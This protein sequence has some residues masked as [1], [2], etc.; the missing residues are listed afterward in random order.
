MKREDWTNGWDLARILAVFAITGTSSAFFP[1]WLM[2][3]TGLEGG[4]FY[5]LVYFLLITPIYMVILLFVAYIFGKFSYF[6]NYEK[7]VV[8]W[9]GKKLGFVRND[10]EK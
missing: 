9:F 2:P 8:R 7:K 3:Y 10:T 6:Y 1:K 5:W 4:F